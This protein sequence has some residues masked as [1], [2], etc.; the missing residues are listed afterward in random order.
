MHVLSTFSKK[1]CSLNERCFLKSRA[2][3]IIVKN[4]AFFHCMFRAHWTRNRLVRKGIQYYSTTSSKDWIICR[5]SCNLHWRIILWIKT[6]LDSR[7]ATS[8]EKCCTFEACLVLCR[9]VAVWTE[10]KIT[11]I[12]LC[13]SQKIS[14]FK[15]IS[16]LGDWAYTKSHLSEFLALGMRPALGTQKTPAIFM[17]LNKHEEARFVCSWCR[18]SP[19]SVGNQH[20]FGHCLC[21]G[22]DSFGMFWSLL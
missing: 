15:H 12:L 13:K 6:A 9:N 16:S 18:A 21:K 4:T 1:D 22:L 7:N 17:T 2:C 3:E 14:S 5:Y 8:S 20:R 10:K 19:T 11:C